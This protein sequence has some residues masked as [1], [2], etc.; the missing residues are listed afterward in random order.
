MKPDPKI[1]VKAAEIIADRPSVGCCVALDHAAGMFYDN[2]YGEA[3]KELFRP[4]MAERQTLNEE[5]GEYIV[6]ICYWWHGSQK[7]EER[8]LA[9]LFMHQIAKNP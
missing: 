2:P 3:F 7:T 5:A 8:I 9:L 1:Y 4:T 6:G